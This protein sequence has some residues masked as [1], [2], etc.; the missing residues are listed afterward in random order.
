[1]C[2]DLF[3]CE[4]DLFSLASNLIDVVA[5][6][7]LMCPCLVIDSVDMHIHAHNNEVMLSRAQSK[8]KTTTD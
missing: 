6:L 7:W 1:M 8:M 2:T 3:F 4:V 5:A